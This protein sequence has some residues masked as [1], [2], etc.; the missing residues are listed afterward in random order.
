MIDLIKP[1]LARQF[2]NLQSSYRYATASA[3]VLPNFI[4]IGAQKGGTTSLYEYLC[5]HHQILGAFSKEVHFFDYN[6]HLG[7][8]W[9]LSNFPTHWQIE[10]RKRRLQK[11][12]ITGEA[13]PYYM[14]HP[15]APARIQDHLS[16]VK[17]IALLRNPV[18]R[19]F[20][21][22]Q[23]M[24]RKGVE[25]RKFEDALHQETQLLRQDLEVLEENEFSRAEAHQRRSY[26]SRGIY[27]NQLKQFDYAK[28]KDLLYIESSERFFL[29][30]QVVYDEVVSF[31][32]I[33]THLLKRPN[34]RNKGEYKQKIDPSL[35]EE[36]SAYYE[37]YNQELFQYLGKTFEW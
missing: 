37:P 34:P 9:Y 3:R 31:L 6:Y 2:H 18:D 30:P 1:L 14:F 35:Y 33:D 32:G 36:L 22:Y 4:I 29:E 20:S 16:D 26:L 28:Q 11:N 23:M 13:T 8:T 27:I 10:N 7:M 25:T 19:A 5:E 17:F 15:T 12:V 24:R 21:H